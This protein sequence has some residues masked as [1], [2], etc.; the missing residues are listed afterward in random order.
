MNPYYVGLTGYNP[1]DYSYP[2]SYVNAPNSP[3][4]AGTYDTTPKEYTA[5]RRV[6]SD[7]FTLDEAT[8][9]NY[10]YAGDKPENITPKPKQVGGLKPRNSDT[11]SGEVSGST[12]KPKYTEDQVMMYGRA[13]SYLV[14]SMS[15][16]TNGFLAYDSSKLKTASY[17]FKSRQYE[18]S[19]DLLEKNITD[20][21]RAARMDANVNKLQN[22][23]TKDKQKVAMSA[24]GFAVGKGSYKSTFAT[25]DARTNYNIAMRM[26]KADLQTAEVTRKV[27]EYRAR[28]EIEKGN[29]KIS[30]IMGKSQMTQGIIS[31]IGNLVNAGFNF[32]VGGWGLSGSN[33]DTKATNSGG[34]NNGIKNS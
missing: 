24:S 27:G 16:F 8:K 33:A 30:R 9:H 22:R 31:G 6:A 32:Y 15:D 11:N 17:D 3:V 10:A 34:K 7:A 25:T 18:R 29:A 21:N 2:M 28:A 14:Q 12:A 19:A 26:L 5:Q 13:A 20:I 23:E 4:P 1:D